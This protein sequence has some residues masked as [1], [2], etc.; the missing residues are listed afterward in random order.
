MNMARWTNPFLRWAVVVEIDDHPDLSWLEQTD[1]EMGEGFEAHATKRL[2]DYQRGHWYMVGVIVE[3]QYQHGE[4]WVSLG[5]ASLW[6]IESDSGDRYF[7]SIVDDLKKEVLARIE[8]HDDMGA[9][10]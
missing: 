6:G 2:A 10:A 4:A 9:L 8:T 3:L 1:D 7:N 5:E